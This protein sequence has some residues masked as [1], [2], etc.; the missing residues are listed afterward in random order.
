MLHIR[1]LCPLG[2]WGSVPCLRAK[3]SCWWREIISFST[4]KS[5]RLIYLSFSSLNLIYEKRFLCF[6]HTCLIFL[7]HTLQLAR[8]QSLSVCV[9]VWERLYLV[10]ITTDHRCLSREN[11]AVFDLKFWHRR[12]ERDVLGWLILMSS[13][14]LHHCF[15]T[16]GRWLNKKWTSIHVPTCQSSFAPDHEEKWKWQDYVPEC[17]RRGWIM[18]LGSESGL[19]ARHLILQLLNRVLKGLC[20]VQP[21]NLPLMNTDLKDEEMRP[22]SDII[23]VFSLLFQITKWGSS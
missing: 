2:V 10:L 23:V 13:F 17:D 14:L 19:W 9:C 4:Q 5:S 11:G 6:D 21:V 1:C 8:K 7:T 22:G 18:E 3:S 15:P 12:L 20:A 16:P